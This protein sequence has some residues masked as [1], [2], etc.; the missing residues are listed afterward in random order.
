MIPADIVSKLISE[1]RLPALALYG[2]DWLRDPISSCSL[3]AQGMWFRLMLIMHD[4]KPYGHLVSANGEPLNEKQLVRQIGCGAAELRRLRAELGAS[5]IPGRTGDGDYAPIFV[6]EINGDGI[7]LSPMRVTVDG[8]I[9][10]RR[11]IRDQR[12]RIVR[13]LAPLFGA[14]KLQR[15]TGQEVG[16][17]LTRVRARAENENEIGVLSKSPEDGGEGVGEGRTLTLQQAAVQSVW[18]ALEHQTSGFRLPTGGLVARWLRDFGLDQV[19]AVISRES[20]KG[21]L[22]GKDPAYLF[23]CLESNT[24][25]AHGTTTG[26]N[27]KSASDDNGNGQRKRPVS[28]ASAD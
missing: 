15:L 10:S 5:G 4:A 23:R 16:Q 3:A 25:S 2:G 17:T 13:K 11:M 1:M 18:D 19:L 14:S 8:V 28:Y 24:R 7:D 26:T 6:A 9:Y 27:R 12:L 22:D 20:A 21:N